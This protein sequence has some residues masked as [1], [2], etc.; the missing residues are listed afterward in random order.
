MRKYIIKAWAGIASLLL[1]CTVG[2]R[3][4]QNPTVAEHYT[5]EN[6]VVLYVR[7]I[8]CAVDEVHYQIGITECE[9]ENLT[10]VQ[11]SQDGIK[12]LILWDNSLSVMKKCEN[13]VR[14]I[15]VDMVANR[16]PGEQFAIAIIEKETTYLS[17]FTDDYA[18]L[19]Q[20]IETVEGEDKDVYI[21]ENLYLAIEALNDM[22]DA[23]YKRI[24]L[25]SDGMDATEIGYSRSEL[26]TLI[27][28]TPYP[29]YTIGVLSGKNQEALQDFFG[30]SRITGTDY[31][32]LNEIEDDMTII[33][34]FSNDYAAIQVRA[35]VPLAI[36]DGSEQNS[37][38]TLS[39]GG[40]SLIVQS[41]VI[42]PFA[43]PQEIVES[44]EPELQ[45][46]ESEMDETVETM[47]DDVHVHIE[48][49]IWLVVV[50]VLVVF[51]I[52]L[53][54]L[55]IKKRSKNT[56]Q[57]GYD[58]EKLDSRIKNE[59]YFSG[60]SVEGA[61]AQTFKVRT[62]TVSANILKKDEKTQ[63]L[64]EAAES[65]NHIYRIIL[66]NIKDSVQT[67]QCGIIDKVIIG[68]NTAV[69]NLAIADTAVSEKH[70]EIEC[71]NGKFYVKDLNSSNG[72]FVN[73]TRIHASTEIF[74]GCILR[75]GRYEY[76][77][78]IEQ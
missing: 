41:G 1:V 12:T 14:E 48:L 49:P 51:I 74:I 66:Q 2:V 18:T 65:G 7:G 46:V 60:M 28:R 9:V 20:V 4:A 21:I 53:I 50:V 44:N 30:L 17:D 59:R 62:E 78:M 11:E 31:F 24:I 35:N 61:G 39:V 23:G 5:T 63:M 45:S 37:Q 8:E 36:Q 16:I 70:C 43:R 38:L 69:C 47:E 10:T 42:L 77:F 64:F 34:A 22:Q 58:Y 54:A 71:Q 33:Q 40:E 27:A 52:V 15:L 6:G 3:A 19:K 29:I 67:Y 32:Y 57:E 72:T 26:D 75:L 76:R 68:R 73:G 13:R 25:I 55:L 56:T